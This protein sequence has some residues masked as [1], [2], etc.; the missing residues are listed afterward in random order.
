MHE[1]GAG[2]TTNQAHMNMHVASKQKKKETE[3]EKKK[4]EF[5][6]GCIHRE[7]HKTP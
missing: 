4:G 3:E 7:C 2:R 1:C 6:P 5:K